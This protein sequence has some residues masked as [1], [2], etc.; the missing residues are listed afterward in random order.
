M[1]LIGNLQIADSSS[2]STADNLVIS[3]V[4]SL[5]VQDSG[6]LSSADIVTLIGNLQIADSGSASLSDNVL[7]LQASGLFTINDSGSLSSAGN[8]VLSNTPYHFLPFY[9]NVRNDKLEYKIN[10][11]LIFKQLII[12]HT[13]RLDCIVKDFIITGL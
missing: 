1:T 8:V 7:L 13:G 6:S 2:L 12:D 10:N 3:T 5:V 9:F 4:S 11:A